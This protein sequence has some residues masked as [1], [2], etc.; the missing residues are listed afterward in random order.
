MKTVLALSGSSNRGKSTTLNLVIDLL[1]AAYPHA[2]VE[3]RRYKVD[4]TFVLVIDGRKVGVET[5]GDPASRLPT[6]LKRFV[7]AGCEVIVCAC[8]SY[9]ATTQSVEDL[10][11]RDYA[12]QWF[13]KDRSDHVADQARDNA[14]VA[15]R[16]FEAVHRALDE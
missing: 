12:I 4:R 13:A 5:Q 16:I 7:D 3:E 14:D 15:K 2:Q 11:T 9:G 6:S 8:R 1:K 10:A